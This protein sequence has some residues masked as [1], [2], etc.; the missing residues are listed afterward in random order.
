MGCKKEN[1]EPMGLKGKK[2][3]ILW[4]DNIGALDLSNNWS[5]SGRTRYVEVCHYFLWELKEEGIVQ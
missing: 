1:S 5:V 3:M 4:M 2:L